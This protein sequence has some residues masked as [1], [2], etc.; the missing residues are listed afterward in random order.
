VTVPAGKPQI[1]LDGWG[2]QDTHETLNSF[3]WGPDGWLY[4]CH[5]VFTHS[6]VGKPGAPD[7]ERVP[8]NAGVWRYHPTR[9]KFEVFAHGT[10]NPWGLD[11]NDHGQAFVS[12]CVIPHCFHIIQGGRY[13]RQAGGHFNPHT[14]NDIKTIADHLHWQ[15][16]NPWAGNNK[17]DVVGGGH[18]HCGLMCYLGGSWPQEYRGQLFMGNIHGRRINQ[19]TLKPKG[20][21]YVASHGKDLLL[22]NDS[23]ARFINMRYGPDGNVYVI[24][25]Y[26]KQACHSGNVDVWDRTN[27]RIYKISHRGSKPVFGID[28]QKKTK[29]EL[30]ELQL[31]ANDWY[32]RHAR[33]LLQERGDDFQVWGA[34]TKMLQTHQDEK[35]RLRALWALH[36]N[37]KLL[38]DNTLRA[39]DDSSEHVRAWTIRLMFETGIVP[40]RWMDKVATMARDDKS[41]V[42]RLEIA[43]VVQH[44]PPEHRWRY[45]DA[46]LS[47]IEDAD[48]QNLPLMYWYAIEPLAAEDPARALALAL[49]GKI[50]QLHGFMIRRIGAGGDATGLLIDALAKTP[51]AGKQLTFL[52]ALREALKGRRTVPMPDA[53]PKLFAKF[54]NLSVND[55]RH[56]QAVCLA[57]TFGNPGPALEMVKGRG[58]TFN[59]AAAIGALLDAGHPKLTPELH[60]LLDSELRGTNGRRL[61]L[62]GLAAYDDPATPN[63]I[64]RRFP[65]FTAEERTDALNTLASRPSF[66]RALLAAVAAKKFAAQEVSADIVRQLRNLKDKDVSKRINEAWGVVRDSPA[67][68]VKAIA[69]TKKMLTTA[70][71]MP[72]DLVQGRAIFNKTC[73]QCHTLFGVGAKVGPDLTGSNR[74]NLDYLLENIIDPSAVIPKEYAATVIEMKDG[75]TLTGII[76]SDTKVAL[77]VVTVNDVLTLPRQ[78]VESLT[79]SKISM[80]PDDLLRPFGEGEVRALIA[81]LQSP[82]QVLLPGEKK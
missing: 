6:K 77:T 11:F 29:M 27:G 17:S 78:E 68:R 73:A 76:R 18:A 57:V 9:H 49:N 32:V 20:S 66:A 75:R 1:V 4:G 67:E 3:I 48:D 62:R 39:L 47:H 42:V 50:P 63:E 37:D 7:K 24:D 2:Y 46:L 38:D 74:A 82:N 36:V 43:S 33:R 55:D 22:A 25:W 28:L 81:Y 14:Y 23:W 21:G 10:S 34:L 5:G 13:H 60:W 64:L 45:A 59:Q 35:R 12:S 40:D 53:W 30:V 72:P 69:D 51:D 56:P 71:Q 65:N 44:F 41:P 26:D 79:E 80:M 16:A 19:D 31:E 58:N 8:L 61:A 54:T 70:P 15:G 52:T